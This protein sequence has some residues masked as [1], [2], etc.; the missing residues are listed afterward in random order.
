MT[1]KPCLS[2]HPLDVTKNLVD[3]YNRQDWSTIADL[4]HPTAMFEAPGPDNVV[5][6][7]EGVDAIVEFLK[8]WVAIIPDARATTKNSTFH[9]DGL[10]T[11]D[12]VWSGTHSG[13]PFE[14]AEITIPASGNSVTIKGS[15]EYV[16]RDGKIIRI[17]DQ[18]APDEFLAAFRKKSS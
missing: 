14:W 9:G 6:R 16:V 12:V 13:K 4:L 18:I 10:V 1:D 17:T 2:V 15:T 8:D 5:E 11:C 7:V 3:A